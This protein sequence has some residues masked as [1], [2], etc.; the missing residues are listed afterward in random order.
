MVKKVTREQALE[1]VRTLISWA[2]DDPNRPDLLDTPKRVVEAYKEF[3][4]GYDNVLL[5]KD[6]KTYNKT[7]GY[8]DIVLLRDIRLESYCE[9]H[10][11]PVVGKVSIGYIPK[12]K[13]IGLSKLARITDLFAKRLQLQERLVVQIGNCIEELLEPKGVAIIIEADHH[14][15]T[16]RGVH[17]AGA[18]MRTSHFTGVFKQD[19]KKQEFLNIHSAN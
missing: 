17:K 18:I 1:A 8:D 16:T 11:C 3:F 19:A 9:H 14:C 2:G 4:S 15:L 7:D 12:K 6:V 5:E 10:M 13:I